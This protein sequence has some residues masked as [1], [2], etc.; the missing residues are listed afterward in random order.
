[1]P[2]EYTNKL[3]DLLENGDYITWETVARECLTY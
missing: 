2:R 1:M 3:I